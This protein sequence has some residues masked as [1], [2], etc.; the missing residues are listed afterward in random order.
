MRSFAA[1]RARTFTHGPGSDSP[2]ALTNNFTVDGLG[3]LFPVTI[4]CN[5][6]VDIDDDFLHRAA[7][8]S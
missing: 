5:V 6:D 8:T 4:F 2:H 7:R 3:K 1:T